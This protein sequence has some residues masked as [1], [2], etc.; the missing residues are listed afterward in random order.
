[1]N[2]LEL[3]IRQEVKKCP[4]DLDE[5]EDSGVALA[6]VW[7][8][9]FGVIPLPGPMSAEAEADCHGAATS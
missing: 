6:E 1:M 8:S 4:T 9:A 7:A 2:L 5:E 3:S